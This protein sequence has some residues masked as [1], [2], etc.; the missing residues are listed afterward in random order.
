MGAAESDPNGV[1]RGKF[2]SRPPLFQTA[3]STI[4]RRVPAI[5]GKI[6]SIDSAHRLRSSRTQGRL[7]PSGHLP[8]VV[9]LLVLEGAVRKPWKRISPTDMREGF[10]VSHK[11]ISFAGCDYLGLAHDS[12]VLAAAHDALDRDG[13]GT[14]ASRTTSGGTPAHDQLEREFST[15]LDCEDALLLP[16]GGFASLVLTK[17]NLLPGTPAWVDSRAHPSLEHAVTLAGATR[18]YD[19]RDAQW[20]LTD[21]VFPSRGEVADLPDLL[22]SIGDQPK[23]RV[24]VDDAHGLGVIGPGGRGTAS[25]F[26]CGDSRVLGVASFAKAFGTAGGIAWGSRAEIAAARAHN[27]HV[28][29]TALPPSTVAATIAALKIIR[30][31]PE[32]H[33]ALMRAIGCAQES[34]REFV[35][36]F[37]PYPLPV[38]C[39]RG[40]SESQLE[41]ISNTLLDRGFQIPFI[42]YPGGPKEG[43]LR[44]SVT[45]LHTADQ[46]TDLARALADLGID[47]DQ[48]RDVSTELDNSKGPD[49]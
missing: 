42:R 28:G 2:P 32:R 20:I 37:P 15:W 17:A 29:S 3:L 1:G 12:R 49:R 22:R 18:V 41:Q 13:F 48:P 31:E 23:S 11:S 19:R 16:S 45:A 5:S 7:P 36:Q 33:E 39:I 14:G 30:D 6:T 46:I 35:A 25:H 9:A 47:K 40:R 43:Y 27:L 34:L 10:K 24:L 21:G 26:K 38:F 44:G 8:A 4:Y